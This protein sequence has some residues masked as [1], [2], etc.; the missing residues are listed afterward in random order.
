MREY[1]SIHLDRDRVRFT[2]EGKI[3]VVDAIG[4]LL[5]E[6]RPETLWEKLKRQHPQLSA[7]CE[8]YHFGDTARHQVADSEGWEVIEGILFE[9]I[10]DEGPSR[11]RCPEKEDCP[12]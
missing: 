2:P 6:C 3:A 12:V 1:L 4:A 9:F 11:H 8:D 10:L 7:H 5:G